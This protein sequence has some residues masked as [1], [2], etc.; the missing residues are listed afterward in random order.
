MAGQV[1]LPIEREH[2]SAFAGRL[3]PVTDRSIRAQDSLRRN[4]ARSSNSAFL[5]ALLRYGV[6][7]GLPNM[8][9]LQCKTELRTLCLVRE[10][11]LAVADKIMAEIVE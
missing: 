11:E 3:A 8:S 2:V 4:A 6:E 7:H 1:N 9:R 5:R 10:E